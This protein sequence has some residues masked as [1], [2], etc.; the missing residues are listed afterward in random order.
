[1]ARL[2]DAVFGVKTKSCLA[3]PTGGAALAG[4]WKFNSDFSYEERVRREDAVLAHPV[5]QR[6]VASIA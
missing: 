4:G 3:V 1:M 5:A 2:D 6:T